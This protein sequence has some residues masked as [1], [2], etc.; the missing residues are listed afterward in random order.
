MKYFF[1]GSLRSIGERG[2][3]PFSFNCID[4]FSIGGNKPN[5]TNFLVP[6]DLIGS[7]RGVKV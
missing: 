1:Q 2:S 7:D 4:S 6:Y 3:F 5:K